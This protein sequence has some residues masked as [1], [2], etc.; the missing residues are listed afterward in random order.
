MRST[1]LIAFGSGVLPLLALPTLLLHCGSSSPSSSPPADAGSDVVRHVIDAGGDDGGEGGS[2]VPP[3]GMQLVKSMS[4]LQ[5]DA[6][7]NDGYAIYTD[8]MTNNVYAISV[9][10]GMPQTVASGVGATAVVF[11]DGPAAVVYANPNGSQIG[12]LYV[13]T[14][15]K[16]AQM[17]SSA[18][19]VGAGSIAFSK[20]YS[21]V[22]F[23]D[24][25]TATTTSL[26]VAGV[27]GSGKSTLVSM[28]V[29][30]SK[31][32]PA[33]A[34]VGN[35]ALTSACT[36]APGADAGADGATLTRY[37]AGS[38]TPSV[39]STSSYPGAIIANGMAADHVLFFDSGGLEA[40]A[41]ASGTTAKI[42]PDGSSFVVTPDG[43]KVVYGTTVTADGGAMSPG[44]YKVSPI[45]SPSPTTLGTGIDAFD[46]ISPDGNWVLGFT[47][48]TQAP[49]YNAVLGSASTP[50][51]PQVLVAMPTTS[52]IG[53]DFTTDSKYC[54]FTDS[55]TTTK[56]LEG[57]VTSGNLN[58]VAVS[59][60]MPVQLGTSVWQEAAGP[61]SKVIFNPN[62][63]APANYGF[64]TADLQEIDLSKGMSSVKTLVSQADANF[65]LTA[66]KKTIVYSYSTGG[67]GQPSV[68]AGLWAM[69][70]P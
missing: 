20:D 15:A 5:V 65:Y 56:T 10:G 9:T 47:Q 8:T 69:P 50:G 17:L 57:S 25:S 4:L 31:C 45:A 36:M 2:E 13:W 27:D 53:D 6:V 63:N 61:G 64:G 58:A 1:N 60:G 34:F 59:G 37:A 39:I 35:D 3:Q 21:H 22:A 52:A 38:W 19:Q 48:Q 46:G 12:Q 51:T 30:S 18:S 32:T 44:P 68:Q 14:A 7:T 24:G 66:D 33:V 23:E 11:A 41:V 49:L 62:W 67:G 26:V 43:S 29:V 70:T 42:D 54:L 40:Y 55:I 16:G 28:A